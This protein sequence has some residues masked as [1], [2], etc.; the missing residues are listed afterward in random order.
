[1][2]RMEPRHG[3]KWAVRPMILHGEACGPLV[4]DAA[5]YDESPVEIRAVDFE[6]RLSFRKD[7]RNIPVG[8]NIAKRHLE[9][10]LNGAGGLKMPQRIRTTSLTHKGGT[11]NGR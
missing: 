9:I 5:Q 11:C 2:R 3:D 6:V 4:A 7:L 1:M 10:D 8:A